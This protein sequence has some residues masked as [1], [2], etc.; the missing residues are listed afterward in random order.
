VVSASADH[1]VEDVGVHAVVVAELKLSDVQRHI[2][3]TDFVERADNA[4]LED[5]PE[6]LNRIRVNCAD[7]VLFAVVVHH[8]VR[9]CLVQ[10]L[11]AAPRI[12]RQQADFVGNNFL[13]ESNGAFR[14]YA[15]QN[16][17]DDVTLALDRAK[18]GRLAGSGSASHAV[19]TLI[20]VTVFV[21]AADIGF[22]N[23]DDTAKLFLRLY[24][25]GANLVAH[26]PRGFVGA[27]AHLPHDLQRANS[28]FAG[29]HQ[30]HDLEPVAE[31]LV[32]VLKD[33][34]D[35]YREAV[36]VWRAFLALPMPLA[37]RQV[38]DGGI[39]AARAANALRPAAGFQIRFRRIFVT[40]GKAFLK[41]AFR[42]LVDWL[43]TSCHGGYLISPSVGGYCHG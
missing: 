13:Y 1:C 20:P 17:G 7:N 3:G 16:A 43:R 19:V 9:I 37:R 10:S 41:L 21:L 40:D 39:A 14:G 35:H 22:I 38:I 8:A 4:A 29:R 32:R 33:R 18:D 30:M 27:E 42:H 6:A 23:L 2:F 25:R 15:F 31:R 28:L 24:H 26:A 12:R 5:R 11:V 36:A 34:V